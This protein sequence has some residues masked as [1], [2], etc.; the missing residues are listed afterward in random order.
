MQNEHSRFGA[1]LYFAKSKMNKQTHKSQRVSRKKEPRRPPWVPPEPQKSN[2][3]C[4]QRILLSPKADRRTPKQKQPLTYVKTEKVCFDM[5]WAALGRCTPFKQTFK[6][7]LLNPKTVPKE[8][9]SSNKN[10]EA[11]TQQSNEPSGHNK[12][13]KRTLMS[14]IPIVGP[15]VFGT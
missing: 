7:N 12:K 3:G 10:S 15:A 2:H 1:V 5:A 11:T 13:N 4:S 9:T 14:A 8:K 6:N